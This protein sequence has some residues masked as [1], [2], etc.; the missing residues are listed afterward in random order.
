MENLPSPYA[1][2]RSLPACHDTGNLCN[3]LNYSTGSEQ[4]SV[5]EAAFVAPTGLDVVQ[6]G[7]LKAMRAAKEGSPGRNTRGMPAPSLPV[8]AGMAPA[9]PHPRETT[10]DSH[11]RLHCWDEHALFSVPGRFEAA[12]PGGTS[13]ALSAPGAAAPGDAP[14]KGTGCGGPSGTDSGCARS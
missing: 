1:A 10:S 6:M 5:Q 13:G 12:G 9:G 3:E 14:G 8:I 4:G 11:S 7:V 2:R